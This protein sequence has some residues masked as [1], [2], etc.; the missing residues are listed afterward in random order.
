MDD[1]PVIVTKAQHMLVLYVREAV[2]NRIRAQ[3]E[4]C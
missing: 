3:W 2:S 1:S 4:I